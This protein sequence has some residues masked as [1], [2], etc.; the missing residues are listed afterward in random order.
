V[1]V[2]LTLAVLLLPKILRCRSDTPRRQMRRPISVEPRRLCASMSRA[3][4]SMLLAPSMMLF[5][6]RSWADPA[7]QNGVLECVIPCRPG[8][9]LEAFRRQ[10]WHLAFALAWG[11]NHAA[12]GAALFWW[13][14]PVLVGLICWLYGFTAWTSRTSA[15][16]IARRWGLFLIRRRLR[17][18][19]SSWPCAART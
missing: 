19:V 14:T 12:G 5:T 10:K 11:A 15:G 3:V 16:R 9:T 18:R 13:L 8:V 17:R 7:G 2:W 1:L 4:F 6:R